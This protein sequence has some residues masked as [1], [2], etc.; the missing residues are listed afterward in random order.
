MYFRSVE[1]KTMPA[2]NFEGDLPNAEAFIRAAKSAFFFAEFF[3]KNTSCG[4]T[5]LNRFEHRRAHAH[6]CFW[7][8]SPGPSPLVLGPM[9]MESLLN[10]KHAQGGYLIDCIWGIAPA[11]NVPAVMALKVCGVTVSATVENY[12]WDAASQKSV[13]GVHFHITRSAF[14]KE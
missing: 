2:L 8:P 10:L 7:R 12:I 13:D 11:A 4:F 14:K 1:E 5:W 6:F 3:H 9:V